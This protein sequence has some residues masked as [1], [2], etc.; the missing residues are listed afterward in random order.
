MYKD[1]PL[2]PTKP[3]PMYLIH[4]YK[5]DLALNKLEWLICY[6]TKPTKSNI[7]NICE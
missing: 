4:M 7:S 3:N 6:K 5:E 2:N 1:I